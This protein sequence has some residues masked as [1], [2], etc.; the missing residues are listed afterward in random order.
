M[1]GCSELL[2]IGRSG[3]CGEAHGLGSGGGVGRLEALD[4]HGTESVRQRRNRIGVGVVVIEVL[5]FSASFMD[6]GICA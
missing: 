4:G 2:M 6:G 5:C 1:D 3:D